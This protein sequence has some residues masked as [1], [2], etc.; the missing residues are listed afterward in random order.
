MKG[1]LDSFDYGA[2]GSQCEFSF[3][4]QG[5]TSAEIRVFPI[6]GVDELRKHLTVANPS[7]AARPHYVESP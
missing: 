4:G 7:S 1:L 5:K 6:A 3:S 2:A